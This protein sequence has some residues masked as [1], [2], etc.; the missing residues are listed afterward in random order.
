MKERLFKFEHN[1][2]I[3]LP[4]YPNNTTSSQYINLYTELKKKKPTIVIT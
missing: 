2:E 3:F 4:Y 1:V